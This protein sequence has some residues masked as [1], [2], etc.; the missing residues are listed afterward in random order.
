MKKTT[1]PV[2][3]IEDVLATRY[4]AN[5]ATCDA[6]TVEWAAEHMA[7]IVGEERAEAEWARVN[8]GIERSGRYTATP[9]YG[10]KLWTAFSARLAARAAK[11]AA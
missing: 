3:K 4:G 9:R 2:L 11:R 6:L 10:S 7:D 1:A 8:R 5:I